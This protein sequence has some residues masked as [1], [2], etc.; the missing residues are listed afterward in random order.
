MQ[1]II[2]NYLLIIVCMHS[3]LSLSLQDFPMA[4]V[5]NFAVIFLLPYFL[6][7]SFANGDDLLITTKDG[8]VQGKLLPVLN[9]TVRGFLGIPYANPPMG[10]LR[11]RAPEPVNAW[12]GVK[13]AT[14]YSNT[15]IQLV[16]NFFPG[17]RNTY[18]GRNN[19]L[20]KK[21]KHI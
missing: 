4:T 18:M 21:N 11:F 13:N 3:S 19:R 20:K 9:G 8:Q 7:L 6:T 15:C 16:D 2:Q 1:L 12:Q 14:N 10:Q 17:R 5:S